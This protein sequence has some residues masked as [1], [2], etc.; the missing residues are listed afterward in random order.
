M[1]GVNMNFHVKGLV[2]SKYREIKRKKSAFHF[3]IFLRS[4]Y[5][6]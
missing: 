6:L 2:G 4:I 1:L 5:H 3:F